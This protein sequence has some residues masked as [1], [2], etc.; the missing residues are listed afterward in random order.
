MPGERGGASKPRS[1]MRPHT[2]QHICPH[3]YMLLRTGQQLH[4]E[5]R[6]ALQVAP[7]MKHRA[8]RYGKGA[9]EQRTG[10]QGRESTGTNWHTGVGG[11][12]E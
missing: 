5:V 11:I 1:N 7:H 10:A 8:C 3:L 9:E 6:R 4:T 12:R 2:A